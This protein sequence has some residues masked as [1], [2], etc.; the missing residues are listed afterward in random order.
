MQWLIIWLGSHIINLLSLRLIFFR[1]SSLLL[2]AGFTLAEYVFSFEQI[3][4]SLT[5]RPPSFSKSI[6]EILVTLYQILS[7]RKVVLHEFVE[8]CFLFMFPPLDA[9][10]ASFRGQK[11]G[12]VKQRTIR[13][14]AF[15]QLILE[16]FWIRPAII[17]DVFGGRESCQ[18][19]TL[20]SFS[21]DGTLIRWPMDST[22][23]SGNAVDGKQG[24]SS[25]RIAVKALK[26]GDSDIVDILQ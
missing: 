11:P 13:V 7:T 5:E 18:S 16:N 22:L 24:S 1:I 4:L 26:V 6:V 10:P 25:V 23:T 2:Q 20:L 9:L 15:V 19:K 14:A 3:L 21:L 8:F 12:I 17:I